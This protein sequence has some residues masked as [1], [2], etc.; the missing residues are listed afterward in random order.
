MVS[1]SRVNQT[2]GSPTCMGAWVNVRIATVD[3]TLGSASLYA[4][5]ETVESDGRK[6]AWSDTK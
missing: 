5:T 6:T 1:N 4:F 2:L 3:L